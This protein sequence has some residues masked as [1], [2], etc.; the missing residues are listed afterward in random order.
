VRVYKQELPEG[1][2]SKF[3]KKIGR[4]VKIVNSKKSKKK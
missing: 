2:K 3:E 4:K 1:V